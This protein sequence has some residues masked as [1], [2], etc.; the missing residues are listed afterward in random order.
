MRRVRRGAPLARRPPARPAARRRGPSGCRPPGRRSPTAP[1]PSPAWR[2]SPYPAWR[3]ALGFDP[4]WVV[5]EV[6]LAG[7]AWF[8]SAQEAWFQQRFNDARLTVPR[9]VRTGTPVDVALTLVPYERV[10][11]VDLTVELVDRF[12]VDVVRRGRT[13]VETRQ[14]V[15]ERVVLARGDVLAGRRAHA[16]HL[17]FDAP[18]PSTVHEHTGRHHHGERARTRSA[19]S[20][21]GSATTRATC[22]STAASSCARR[23]AAASGAGASSS[24][25]SS[26]T[27]ARRRSPRARSSAASR[28][29][30]SDLARRRHAATATPRSAA[31]SATAPGR[32]RRDR[33]PPPR[34]AAA[35]PAARPRPPGTC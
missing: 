19:S 2:S 9:H 15:M 30:R 34:P 4:R 25:S 3:T 14:R 33:R 7:A 18:F 13:Q 28:T 32:G 35:P 26:S 12:Y 1:S 24:G 27:W 16:F 23:C 22:A 21:P 11:G 5:L 8:A 17:A 20:C 31:P 29:V 10:D 6:A